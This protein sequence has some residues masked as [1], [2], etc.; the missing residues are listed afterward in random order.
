MDLTVF[1]KYSN[2]LS[3]TVSDSGVSLC[4]GSSSSAIMEQ[5]VMN[6]DDAEDMTIC[7][8]NSEGKNQ[9]ASAHQSCQRYATESK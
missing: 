8:E 7:Y 4:E 6:L 3:D 1:Q 2:S 5:H 9:Y